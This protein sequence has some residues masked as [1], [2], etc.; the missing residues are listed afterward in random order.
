MTRYRLAALAALSL[1]ALLATASI[2]EAQREADRA[3]T[4]CKTDQRGGKDFAKFKT[5][6]D[7][8]Q[9]GPGRRGA[10]PHSYRWKT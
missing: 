10:P 1:A 5:E 4:T 6:V 8:L 9:R 7:R 3:N 2:G